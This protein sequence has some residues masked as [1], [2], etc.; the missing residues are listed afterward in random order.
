[1]Y[2]PSWVSPKGG[3]IRII[4]RLLATP[5]VAVRDP[6]LVSEDDIDIEGMEA[7][8]KKAMPDANA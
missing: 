3:V 8:I 4:H 1:M 5:L 7:D 6:I 2:Q